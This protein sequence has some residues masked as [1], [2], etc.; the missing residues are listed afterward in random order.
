MMIHRAIEKTCAVASLATAIVLA[1]LSLSLPPS[2]EIASGNLM[3]V[4]QFLTFT[5]T[6]FGVDY[7]FNGHDHTTTASGHPK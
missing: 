7:K 2:H 1:F 3:A 4:A 6:I 5:A